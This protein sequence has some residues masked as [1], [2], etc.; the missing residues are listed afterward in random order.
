MVLKFIPYI[1]RDVFKNIS[2]SKI[3]DY[4]SMTEFR[5]EM[6]CLNGMM[7][8]ELELKVIRIIWSDN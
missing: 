3:L 2:L 4:L 1:L 8:D 6:K 7:N 5:K